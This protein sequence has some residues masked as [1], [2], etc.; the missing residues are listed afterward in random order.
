MT[1]SASLGI[2][3]A[4]TV[5]VPQCLGVTPNEVRRWHWSKTRRRV[6]KCRRDVAL[7]LSQY[8]PPKLP[9]VVTMTRCSVGRCDDDG[10]IGAM[11]C[12][13]D[14]IAKW[15]SVDDSDPRVEW[16]VEQ[17]KVSR[18]GVGVVIRIEA[19]KARVG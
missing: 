16:H 19:R 4:L 15:L 2:T 6:A 8:S 5:R 3:Y 17:Q 12:V 10:A 11:K 9:A 18:A 13:R 14:E 1:T 7:V